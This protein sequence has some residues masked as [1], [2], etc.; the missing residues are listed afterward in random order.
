[1][2]EPNI[3]GGIAECLI[4]AK[5]LNTFWPNEACDQYLHTDFDKLK[6][7]NDYYKEHLG[8]AL[9]LNK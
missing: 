1:M 2:H 5:S 6:A 9:K 3:L 8:G 4:S 7:Q